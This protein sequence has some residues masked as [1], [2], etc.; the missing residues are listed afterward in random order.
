MEK[1]EAQDLIKSITNL[2]NVIKEQN[3]INDT[4]NKELRDNTEAIKELRTRL[5]S[6]A[7]AI[8]N[9]TVINQ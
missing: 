4:H 6:V 1:K 7:N 5:A 2:V 8:S 3:K 9:G